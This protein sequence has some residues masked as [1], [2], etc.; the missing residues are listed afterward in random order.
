ML[1]PPQPDVV[2]VCRYWGAGDFG[3]QWTLAGQRS[4]PRSARLDRLV[5]E[6]DA[7][8]PITAP[9]PSCPASG[10]RS[11][12]LLFGYARAAQDTVRVVRE[13]CDPVGN[14]WL[15][16]RYGLGLGWGEHWLD[17]GVV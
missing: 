4:A 11:V 3:P 6:L 2:L 15:N 17:E 5:R 12:L 14:G 8:K 13:A 1:V 9:L 16:D 10:G 7:L